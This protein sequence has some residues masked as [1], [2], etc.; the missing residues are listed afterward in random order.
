[1]TTPPVC[2]MMTLGDS[3]PSDPVS[4]PSS[5]TPTS[6]L[7]LP[8]TPLASNTSHPSIPQEHLVESSWGDA[9]LLDKTLN[10][11][12]AWSEHILPVLCLSG[13]NIYLDGSL[14]A[15][16]PHLEPRANCNW[17]LNNSAIWAF[18]VMKCVSAEREFVKNCV[19]ADE[20]WSTLRQRPC[21]RSTLSKKLFLS[22]IPL[23]S[24]FPKPHLSYATS[25]DASGI[26]VLLPRKGSCAS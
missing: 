17:R 26:W 10:N 9:P 6:L 14:P 13:L 11:Y 5:P 8:P 18:L 12:T 25:T 24:P 21:P 15:P 20:V 16:S 22:T 3:S 7:P 23:L 4:S 1:M 2:Y 19:S